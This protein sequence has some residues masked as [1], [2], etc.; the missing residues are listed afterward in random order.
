MPPRASTRHGREALAAVLASSERLPPH[1]LVYGVE[2]P[3]RP[4]PSLEELRRDLAEDP[5]LEPLREA[6]AA[7]GHDPEVSAWMVYGA[8]GHGSGAAYDPYEWQTAPLREEFREARE[9]FHRELAEAEAREGVTVD[10]EA[11]RELGLDVDFDAEP[12]Q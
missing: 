11:L 7:G 2:R 12:L 9:R 1:L 4:T 10:R 3:A 8:A 5:E 6:L